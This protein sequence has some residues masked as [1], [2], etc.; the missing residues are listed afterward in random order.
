[1]RLTSLLL[2]FAALFVLFIIID[3][4]KDKHKHDPNVQVLQS[5]TKIRK[6]D[7]INGVRRP[8]KKGRYH[9]GGEKKFKKPKK[10]SKR[11]NKHS[12]RNEDESQNPD[13]SAGNWED[14]QEKK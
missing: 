2:L 10:K 9:Q 5:G 4:G 14:T 1:M 6:A 12:G 8:S 13:D 11:K 3:G 7:K